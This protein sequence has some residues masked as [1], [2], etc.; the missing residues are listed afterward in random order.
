MLKKFIA[1]AVA[2]T[3]AI[4]SVAAAAA[5]TTSQSADR[6][7]SALGAAEELVG[8][9]LWIVILGALVAAGVIVLAE[10]SDGNVDDLPASP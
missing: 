10:D 9:S 3:L 7:A 4:S 8:G 6:K 1:S 5:P 2:G